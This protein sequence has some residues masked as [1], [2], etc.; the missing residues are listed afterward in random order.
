MKWLAAALLVAIALLQYR[1]WLAEDS[2]DAAA[3]VVFEGKAD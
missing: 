3:V 2:K 1:V